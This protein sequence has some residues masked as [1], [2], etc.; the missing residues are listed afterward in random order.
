VSPSKV[1]PCCSFLT[2]V[3]MVRVPLLWFT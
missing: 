1:S 2:D 3:T